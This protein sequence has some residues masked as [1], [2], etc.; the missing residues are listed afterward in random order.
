M[1]ALLFHPALPWLVCALVC[2]ACAGVVA[3]HERQH[4]A[5]AERMR[6]AWAASTEAYRQALAQARKRRKRKPGRAF[7]WRDSSLET[8]VA[9]DMRLTSVWRKP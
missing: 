6:Q 1:T 4:K 8:R 3:W 5:S 2:A 7:D 9:D